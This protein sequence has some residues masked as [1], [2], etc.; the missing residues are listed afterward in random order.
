MQELSFGE[1]EAPR[2]TCS[3]QWT[4]KS[5]IRLIPQVCL[6]TMYSRK[7]KKNLFH[8]TVISSLH[9]SYQ[10]LI[11]IVNQWLC[12]LELNGTVHSQTAK[13]HGVCNGS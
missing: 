2:G 8:L 13:Y 6:V 10:G 11:L 12:L 9:Y 1:L 5:I 3:T 7:K 4:L